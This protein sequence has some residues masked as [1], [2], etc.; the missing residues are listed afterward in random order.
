MPNRV[1]PRPKAMNLSQFCEFAFRF[2]ID[3]NQRGSRVVR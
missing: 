1:E 2:L 3:L